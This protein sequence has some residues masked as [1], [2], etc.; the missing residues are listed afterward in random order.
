MQ[1]EYDLT[2]KVIVDV[3]PAYRGDM[4]H[5]P[6]DTSV[7]ISSLT[8]NEKEIDLPEKTLAEIKEYAIELLNEESFN[9]RYEL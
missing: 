9:R 6:T 7:E 2:V 8:S 1:F 3:E 4:N 5:P